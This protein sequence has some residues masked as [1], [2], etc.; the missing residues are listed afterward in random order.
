[1]AELIAIG[2]VVRPQGRKGELLAQPLS[3]R[4]DRFPSLRS[5]HVAAPDGVCRRVA[6]TG[7]WPHKGRFVLKLD[8]V[9]SIDAA[10]RLRGSELSIPEEELPPLPPGSYYHHQLLGLRVL[11]DRDGAELGCVRG[12]LETGGV[13]VL[14]IGEADA[15]ILIPLARAFVPAVDLEAGALRVRLPEPSH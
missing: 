2:R 12:I 8:G 13:P 15:E 4:P 10:E 9:D 5:V 11:E 14:Q 1:M 3:D 6:V 7:C